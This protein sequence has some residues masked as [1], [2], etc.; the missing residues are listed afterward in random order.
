MMQNTY[1]PTGTALRIAYGGL[2]EQVPCLFI[3]TSFGLQQGKCLVDILVSATKFEAFGEQIPRF[4]YISLFYLQVCPSM[5]GCYML[6]VSHR[7]CIK[8]FSSS[9]YISQSVFQD[10]PTLFQ[11]TKLCC[12]Y[13]SQRYMIC[14]RNTKLPSSVSS[15]LL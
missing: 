8:Q 6:L 2:L 12:W 13:R 1:Q 15:K 7:S 9:S 3:P 10:S 4:T 14:M 5:P 11:L